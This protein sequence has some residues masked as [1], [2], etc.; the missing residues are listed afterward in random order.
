MAKTVIVSLSHTVMTAYRMYKFSNKDVI[1]T[2]MGFN[3]YVN[4]YFKS[5]VVI[6]RW[7]K[8]QNY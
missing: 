8:L 2:M 5:T 1:P 6:F 3:Y 4:F 7:R